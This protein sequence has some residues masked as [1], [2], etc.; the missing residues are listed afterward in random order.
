MEE[1]G[2]CQDMQLV[3]SEGGGEEGEGRGEVITCDGPSLLLKSLG[4]YEYHFESLSLSL[5]LSLSHFDSLSL[6]LPPPPPPFSLSLSLLLWVAM[7]MV[8][9]KLNQAYLAAVFVP[10][11]RIHNHRVTHKVGVCTRVRAI[12]V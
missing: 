2:T 9:K 12:T 1:V 4:S 10:L 7:F 8:T 6:S 5:S 3:Q 11:V